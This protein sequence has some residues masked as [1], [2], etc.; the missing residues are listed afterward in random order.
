MNKDDFIRLT[1]MAHIDIDTVPTDE[2]YALFNELDAQMSVM[3]HFILAYQEYM[4]T[5]HDYT[6]EE[7][8]TMIEAHLLTNICDI[9]NC[10]STSL[11]HAWNRSASATSQTLRK[12]IDKGL[13]YRENAP[14]NAKIF[15]LR[16]TAK[17]LR[18]SDAHK[19]YDVLDTIKTFKSLRHSLSFDEIDTMFKGLQIYSALLNKNN[20]LS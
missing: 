11:A 5:G 16:P 4:N 20:K 9:E 18:V 15:Y 3:Y 17:G 8:L 12:L 7:N 13:I 6:A 14:N 10:T 1:S 19:R 2:L